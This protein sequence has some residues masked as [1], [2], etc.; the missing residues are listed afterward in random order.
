M[1]KSQTTLESFGTSTAPAVVETVSSYRD[2]MDTVLSVASTDNLEDV[3]SAMLNSLEGASLRELAGITESPAFVNGSVRNWVQKLG[4]YKVFKSIALHLS[5]MKVDTVGTGFNQLCI[6]SAPEVMRDYFTETLRDDDDES[7]GYSSKWGTHLIQCDSPSEESGSQQIDRLIDEDY[8]RAE[9]RG[10]FDDEEN[11][12]GYSEEDILGDALC[13]AKDYL[14][15]REKAGTGFVSDL[16]FAGYGGDGENSIWATICKKHNDNES[17]FVI[18]CM[19][20]NENGLVE[21]FKGGE[22][23]HDLLEGTEWIDEEGLKDLK[24]Q[25]LQRL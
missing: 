19:D 14:D 22:L 7:L 18:G 17:H 4:G 12:Y 15:T 16:Y 11:E 23:Y 2:I 25:A 10:D 1:E 3:S 20:I 13:L 8:A 24:L 21:V 6:D 5:E 9:A